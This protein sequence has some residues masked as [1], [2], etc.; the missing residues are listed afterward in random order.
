MR[1]TGGLRD[2]VLSYNE[3]TGEGSGFSFFN[4]NAHDML[5]V[6]ERAVRIFHEQP[7]VFRGIAQRD[8]RGS[9]GWDRSAQVYAQLYRKTAGLPE[10][11]APQP[12]PAEE[13]ASAPEKK[14]RARKAEPKEKNA[15]AKAPKAGDK[16]AARKSAAKKN[17]LK[18]EAK[19]AEKKP[20]AP[21][22]KKEAE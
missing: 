3:Y 1:E 14:P 18:T 10:Q 6:I 9:Y 21:R 12:K 22:K 13:S 5:H 2:T 17:T 11:P 4:Y 20:R 15:A 7:D 8:M 19:P 16:P